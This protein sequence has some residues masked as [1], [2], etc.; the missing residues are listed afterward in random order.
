MFFFLQDHPLTNRSR[1]RQLNTESN[2]K[3]ITLMLISIAFIYIIGDLPYSVFIVIKITFN[4]VLKELLIASRFSFF[5]LIILKFCAYY[6]F[7]RLF[8]IRFKVIFQPLFRCISLS[9]FSKLFKCWKLAIKQINANKRALKKR[10]H[11]F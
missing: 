7:N 6:Y 10:W 3:N 5:F 11:E 1:I 8:R 2:N 4:V 9:I